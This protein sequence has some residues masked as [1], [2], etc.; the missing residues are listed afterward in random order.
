MTKFAKGKRP[1]Y[2]ENPE[3]DKLL[4]MVLALAE[5]VSVLRDRL[6]TI[7]RLTQAKGLLSQTEIE[8]FQLDPQAANEREQ[9]R[10]AYIA[11]ILRI[12]QTDLEADLEAIAPKTK[13]TPEP[14]R[15]PSQSS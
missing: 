3:T 10:A 5:E 14:E 4:A 7:E 12:V 13:V 6:D 2:F 1:I 11:R 9:R 8:T 15:S